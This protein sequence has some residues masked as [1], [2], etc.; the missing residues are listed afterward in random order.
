MINIDYVGRNIS[1]CCAVLLP[2]SSLS[3]L[4]TKKKTQKNHRVAK[5]SEQ[6]KETEP[7]ER[8]NKN[9]NTNS[10]PLIFSFF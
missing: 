10:K 6:Q 3:C 7:A 5:Q 1:P 9:R 4:T 2:I 8:A